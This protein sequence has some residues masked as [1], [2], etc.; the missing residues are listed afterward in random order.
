MLT[1]RFIPHS[2]E[3]TSGPS[4]INQIADTNVSSGIE[5]I[6]ESAG[7]QTDTE[8][9]AVRAIKPT[10]ALDTSDLSIL[11]SVGFAGLPLITGGNNL[12]AYGRQEPLDALPAPIASSVHIKMLCQD[13][14]IVPDSISAQHNQVARLRATL[15]GHLASGGA[16]TP[17]VFSNGNAIASGA[18]QVANCYT[19][20]PVKF[21]SGSST[22][23]QGISALSI[24]FGIGLLKE[25]DSGEVYDTH[26]SIHSRSPRLEFSTK[27]PTLMATVGDGLAVTNFSMYFRQI[28][29]S[30]QRVAAATAT[31]ISVVGTAGMLIPGGMNLVHK[32]SGV[33]H[34]SFVPALNTNLITISATATIPTS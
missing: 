30:G 2:V 34:F 19:T 25:S 16:A 23:V 27:D 32:Q 3:L 9:V 1:S 10:M 31:H 15:H 4:W 26:V 11:T 24:N 12:I 7:S 14:L 22:L 33:A 13:G 6:E 28:A 29:A 17:F 20:G 8:F 18:G 21:T 5:L